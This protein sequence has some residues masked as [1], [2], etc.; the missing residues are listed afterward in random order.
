VDILDNAMLRRGR[1]L[2]MIRRLGRNP[3]KSIARWIMFSLFGGEAI[4]R[5]EVCERSVAD[6]RS[7]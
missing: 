2:G 1:L 6:R 4:D 7:K 5:S 3:Y